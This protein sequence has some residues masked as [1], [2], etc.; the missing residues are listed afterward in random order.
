MGAPTERCNRWVSLK[1]GIPPRMWWCGAQGSTCGF[2]V[3]G[4]A[5]MNRPWRGGDP[6]VAVGQRP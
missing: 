3:S 5:P 6:L 1:T 4:I 2:K